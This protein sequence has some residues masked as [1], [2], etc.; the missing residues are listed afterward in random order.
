[1]ILT[2]RFV[3]VVVIGALMIGFSRYGE[4]LVT[5]GVTLISLVVVLALADWLRLTRGV[6]L[7]VAR[8]CDDKLSLGA[9]NLVTIRVRNSSY[10][11]LRGALRDEYPEDFEARGHVMPLD[12]APR[13]E[14][15]RSYRVTPPKRGDFEFGDTYVRLFGPLG[16]A[17]RQ[18]R[19]PMARHVKVYPNLLD[20]RRYEIGLK[21][22]RAVQPGQRVTRVYGRGTEFESLRDYVPDD[23]FRSVD[24]K[25]TARRGKLVVRQYQQERSQNVMIVLD[26]GRIM[27]PV[28]DG[29]TR[30]DHSINASM[31]L[32][33]V[34]AVKG[35]KV[36]L[37]AFGEDIL[38]YS[39]PRAGKSQTL[40][41]LTLTYNLRDAAGDS[42]Y[43]QAI[44]Y[45]ARK[46][47][48]RS[49]VVVFTDLVDPESSKPMISQMAGLAK[50]HLCM[51]VAMADPAVLAASGIA[52]PGRSDGG[53]SDGGRSDEGRSDR[54]GSAVCKPEDA[55]K[56][57]AARQALQARKLA[58]AQLARTGAIV[59]DVPPGKF[60]PAVVREY[61]EVKGRARL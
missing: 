49:L 13:C 32:A 6:N 14:V 61:L 1:M 22:E 57:A 48:R 24:W 23:E 56:A 40:E 59:V 12:L 15:D 31:M 9:E 35:D 39:P 44:P 36:G 37:M 7:E 17:V 58:A 26:C 45:L 47:T 38:A 28:I 4:E 16:M 33:H 18:I 50:K 5:G 11:P 29:L 19:Y 53:R 60:T 52:N 3:V 20:M 8:T 10:A 46:W 27:G 54:G 55:F 41:L 2:V 43:H 30:L 25:A 34:A 51:C 42:N 21:R